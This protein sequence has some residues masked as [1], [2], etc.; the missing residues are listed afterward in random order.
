MQR[1]SVN[2]CCVGILPGMVI[3]LLV[4]PGWL[5]GAEGLPI[6][7]PPASV[8]K[9]APLE[10]PIPIPVG[11]DVL[12]PTSRTPWAAV[13][14]SDSK[15]NT[16][17]LWDLR[18]R[19]KVATLQMPRDLSDERLMALS[20]N[21]K[22][23]AGAVRS[24]TVEVFS[25]ETEQQVSRFLVKRLEFLDF[26]GSNQLVTYSRD[27][28]GVI[29]SW[30][31]ATGKKTGTMPER[32]VA[33]P[34]LSVTPGGHFLAY[35]VGD[36]L[37]V[38]EVDGMK[39]AGMLPLPR[40]ASGTFVGKGLRFNHDGTKVAVMLAA[41]FDYRLFIFDVA[42]G[43]MQKEVTFGG[44]P[45]VTFRA[46][47]YKGPSLEW[48]PD[49]HAVLVAGKV[50]VDLKIGRPVWVLGDA[51]TWFENP[52]KLPVGPSHIL[53][54]AGRSRGKSLSTEKYPREKVESSWNDEKAPV[55]PGRTVAVQVNA[56]DIRFAQAS[57]IADE[58]RLVLADRLKADGFE[59][60][61]EADV[62]LV[63]QYQEAPGEMMS[64]MSR[65]LPFRREP[66]GKQVRGTK[67]TGTLTW[68]GA[69]KKSLWTGP[70]DYDPRLV[71]IREKEPTEQNLREA[72]Y[73]LVKYTL[74][75]THLPYLVPSEK[76]LPPLPG[77]GEIV[78]PTTLPTRQPVPS[79]RGT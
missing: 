20:P 57:T 66:T 10:K 73:R 78:R 3:S 21:G 28:N 12:F 6:D 42:S 31:P 40:A 11:D 52:R 19:E 54:A 38:V 9:L 51:A 75:G 36:K 2:N 64:E 5:P 22:L 43:E 71:T 77:P 16:R 68:Q 32:D 15:E 58:L 18:S 35:T 47:N 29:E 63:F 65:G 46:S 8:A 1:T 60:A 70:F 13:G 49:G 27:G 41:A 30:D 34:T 76:S 72:V 17:E 53:T 50:V 74:G 67:V 45:E 39:I 62:T 69:G 7:P 56:T 48:F 44:N 25:F 33:I 79:S 61:D 59:V 55:R 4:M 23:F 26:A 37:Q 24:E 14:G